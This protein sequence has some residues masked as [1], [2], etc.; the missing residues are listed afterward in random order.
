MLRH[1]TIFFFLCSV[2]ALK[3]NPHADALPPK[4]L[5][6]EGDLEDYSY[7]GCCGDR[8]NHKCWR[9]GG[10]SLD[11]CS[12]RRRGA[13]SSWE[14][15]LASCL[16]SALNVRENRD[17]RGLGTCYG[18][19][20]GTN[21]QQADCPTGVA[22]GDGGQVQSSWEID[23]NA[24]NGNEAWTTEQWDC[25]CSQQCHAMSPN[26]TA[27][28]APGGGQHGFQ[29]NQAS[30]YQIVGPCQFWSRDKRLPNNQHQ[31]NNVG[32]CHTK[33]SPG[34]YI[35]GCSDTDCKSANTEFPAPNG[36]DL[37]SNNY[38]SACVKYVANSFCDD[39]HMPTDFYHTEHMP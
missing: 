4:E 6:L 5:Q 9:K 8:Y 17:L 30:G 13:T 27:A 39:T 37:R 22:V 25:W 16:S 35:N 7:D 33:R 14:D 1:A 11:R 24:Q 38:N 12:R 21:G 29:G 23:V 28:Y 34:A 32:R 3:L 19:A 2:A 26:G 36:R 10:H 20:F 31:N 15:D 18:T